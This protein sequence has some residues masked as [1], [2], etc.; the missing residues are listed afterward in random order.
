MERSSES[1]S[2]QGGGETQGGGGESTA[3]SPV[4]N[5]TYNLISA[6]ASKLEALEVMEKYSRDDDSGIFQELASDDRRHA[7]RLIQQLRERL[8]SS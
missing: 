7:E 5:A 1:Y 2:M 4:D 6:L 8:G 3:G